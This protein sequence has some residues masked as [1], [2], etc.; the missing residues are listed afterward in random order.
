MIIALTEGVT[1]I[2]KGATSSSIVKGVTT[3]RAHMQNVHTSMK[4][5]GSYD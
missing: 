1:T 5:Q 3:S 4:W 2:T